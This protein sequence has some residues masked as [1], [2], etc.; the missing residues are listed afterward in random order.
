MNTGPAL[1]ALVCIAKACNSQSLKMFNDAIEAYP[2]VQPTSHDTLNT[3]H[4]SQLHTTW[5]DITSQIVDDGMMGG[6]LEDLKDA[7]L[8]R[9]LTALL[10]PYSAVQVCVRVC[11]P[12]FLTYPIVSFVLLCS[13]PTLHSS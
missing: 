13:F 12:C 4:S 11:S 7:M 9:N 3:L 2:E 6:H 8:Q 10:L 5:Y 1:D